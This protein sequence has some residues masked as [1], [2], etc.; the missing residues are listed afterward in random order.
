MT[1]KRILFA[2]IFLVLLGG[3]AIAGTVYYYSQDLPDMITLDDFKPLLVSEVYD[4]NDKKIGEFFRERRKITKTEDIPD[5]VKK[6]FISS[7][8][9]SFYEHKGVNVTAIIRAMIANIKAGRKVQGGSTITQQVAKRIVLKDKAKKYSRKIKEAI[10]ARRMEEHLSKDQI[11]YLYLNEI[12]F[13]QGAYGVAMAS[14]VYFRKPLSEITIPEAALLAGLPQ[15][16]SRYTPVYKPKAAKNRQIYVLNRMAAESH[17]TKKQAQEAINQDLKVYTK[18]NY[19]EKAPYFLETIRQTLVKH[20]TEK[21]LL[22][23]GLKIYTGLDIERQVAAQARVRQGL[24]ELDKRQGYRG[25]INN[26][27][28]AKQVSEFLLKTRDKL[29]S[30]FSPLKVIKPDGTIRKTTKLNLTGLDEEGNKLPNIPKYIK[31]GEI[32][33]AIVTNV[34]D[35]LGL[36]T[37]RFAENKGLIN[38]D[39]MLWAREPNPKVSKKWAKN[40]RNPSEAL[41]KGDIILVKVVAED[42]KSERLR[43]VMANAKSKKEWPKDIPKFSEYAEVEL[44]QEPKA[45]GALLS[46]GNESGDILAMVGGYD[47]KKSKYNCSI[48][49]ARQTGSSFK[50]FVFASALDHGYTPASIL[51]DAPLV[52]KQSKSDWKPSNYTN[53]YKG[54]VLFRAAIAQSLN[55]PTVKLIEDV[56]VTWVAD[57]T[58][59]L[60]VFSPL[61]MDYTLAL[62]SSSVTLYEMTKAFAHFPRLGKKVSPTLIHKVEDQK[63]EIIL[64][65][66]SLDDRFG[67]EID[68]L[69]KYL[70]ERKKV[71]FSVKKEELE[72]PNA[73]VQNDLVGDAAKVEE[74]KPVIYRPQLF[75]NNPEQLIKPTTA[76][77]TTTILKAAI[78]D[79]NATGLRAS[80]IG[81]PAAGKTGTS[82]DEYDAWFLGY[83]PQITTGVWVGYLTERSLGAGE[84][85]GKTALPIWLEYMKDAHTDM[86]KMDFKVP[87]GIMFANIDNV[88]G[89]LSSADSDPKSVIRQAFVIGSE[90]TGRADEPTVEETKNFYK[91][92][93]AE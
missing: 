61:N 18:I 85:G 75:F 48:Q 66:L 43:K 15:A 58:K 1:V 51:I 10:L 25:A 37:V 29:I 80:N 87:S 70:Q 39:S 71:G 34:D 17:I 62:G 16:P 42:F 89:R 78:T 53:K 38:V 82:S 72:D 54:D 83:T 41:K 6:A 8:D 44:E 57:Y 49:A 79:P 88:S 28:D 93:L 26:I 22:D 7:E 3:V 56:G 86:E 60:G 33:E 14:E 5:I 50:A 59:R 32:I 27:T 67:E 76:F 91:D 2:L 68:E 31:K 47:F 20:V 46:I 52:Y 13:G 30:E 77:L 64:D 4:R 65:K 40:V 12:Y 19:E 74:E 36:T 92:D 73:T 55:I 45:Q 9:S 69:D 81:R 35:K 23:E 63:G 24:E 84:G 90:P 11:M 21:S